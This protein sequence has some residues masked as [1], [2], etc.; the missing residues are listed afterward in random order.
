MVLAAPCITSVRLASVVSGDAAR[1]DGGVEP[2]EAVSTCS[3]SW[4]CWAVS[5][6]SAIWVSDARAVGLAKTLHTVASKPVD[7]RLVVVISGPLR[8]GFSSGLRRVDEGWCQFWPVILPI[9][10]P[11]VLAGDCATGGAFNGGAAPQRDTLLAGDPVRY[12]RRGHTN[13]S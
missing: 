1:I 5:F 3:I 13:D 2:Y 4:R 6:G 9:V 10:G 11:Q 8:Y 7:A 12:K